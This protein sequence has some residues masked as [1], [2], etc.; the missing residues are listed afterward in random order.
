MIVR[1]PSIEHVYLCTEFVDFRK[2]ILG[3]SIYV[4]AV[5]NMN[6]F[7]PNLFIFCNK[8]RSHIK[9]LYWDSNGFAMWQKA[10]AKDKFKWPR[11]CTTATL[12]VTEEELL[13]LLDGLDIL[14][15]KPHQPLNFSTVF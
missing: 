9:A 3:L 13:W 6:P 1:R 8:R 5:L 10:L 4:E 12:T 15:M 11:G 7:D 2:Q 14:K